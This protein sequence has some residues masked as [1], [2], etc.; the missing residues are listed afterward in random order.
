M[1][2]PV[3]HIDVKDVSLGASARSWGSGSSFKV[4]VRGLGFLQL[5]D[6]ADLPDGYVSISS[7][8]RCQTSFGS[9]I[10]STLCHASSTDTPNRSAR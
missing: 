4:I 8:K 10:V 5:V 3:T 9:Q 2:Y 1:I 7:T 6:A